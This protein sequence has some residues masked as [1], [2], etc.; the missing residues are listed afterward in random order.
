MSGIIK[1]L[2]IIAGPNGSGKTT[3]YRALLNVGHPNFGVYINAD[4]IENT[5]RTKGILSFQSYDIEADDKELKASFD[6]FLKTRKTN[7]KKDSF[8]LNDNFLILRNRDFLDSYFAGF[9][10]EFIRDKMISWGRPKITIETV[11]SHPSK[12]DLMKMALEKGY[13]VY[14]YYVTTEDPMINVERV[15]ARKEKGEHFVPEKV[16]IDR[17]YKSLDNLYEAVKLSNRAFLFDN[18]GKNANYLAEFDKSKNQ[19]SLW[20]ARTPK[21]VE[22]YYLKK[23][24]E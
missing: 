5:L 2:R 20:S 7:V 8:R 4:E 15:K 16:V 6:I 13:R 19:L 21:W 1:R 17:Y 9:I 10:A 3:V 24:I 12:L 14:L 23:N 18:S 11:M 22:T